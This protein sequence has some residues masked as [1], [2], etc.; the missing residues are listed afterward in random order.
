MLE[1]L[2]HFSYIVIHRKHHFLKEVPVSQTT[3]LLDYII[4]PLCK[5]VN[6]K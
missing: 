3:F 6:S 2:S 5:L 1:I 4:G